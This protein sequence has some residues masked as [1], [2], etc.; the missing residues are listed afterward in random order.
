MAEEK[1]EYVYHNG[2]YVHVTKMIVMAKN[3]GDYS[4]AQPFLV[5]LLYH[6]NM[7]Q[8][9]YINDEVDNIRKHYNL[10]P[11]PSA[12]AP[13]SS[14]NM[15]N[16]EAPQKKQ[17]EIA[18]EY[19][20]HL[21]KNQRET[22]LKEALIQLRIGHEKLFWNKSCWIGVYLVVRDRLDEDL[23]MQGFCK[24]NITPGSWPSKLIIGVKSLSNIRRYIKG[25]DCEKSYYL[26]EKNPFKNLCDK[27]WEIL[28]GLILT[29]KSENN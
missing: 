7:Y 20:I 26:M 25:K 6:A 2:I 21:T 5:S 9:Q 19:Y 14:N 24:L 8:L 23:S 17:A 27:F 1:Y 10:A 18:R 13:A 22:I 11:F 4:L 28:L 12:G 15:P 3:A 16:F 29:K